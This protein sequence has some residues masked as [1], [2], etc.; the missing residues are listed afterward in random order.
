MPEG[1]PPKPAKLIPWILIVDPDTEVT[2]PKAPATLLAVRKRAGTV[3][4]VR[5]GEPRAAPEAEA[6]TAATKAAALKAT[7]FNGAG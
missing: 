4:V 3:P 7:A 5:V 2:F 6:T 1:R